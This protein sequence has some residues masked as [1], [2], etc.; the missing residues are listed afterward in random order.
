[1][2]NK[3]A[4]RAPN[5]SAKYVTS[6]RYCIRAMNAGRRCNFT[7]DNKK[8]LSNMI[9]RGKFIYEQTGATRY[10]FPL[11]DGVENALAVM[12]ITL[13]LTIPGALRNVPM[14]QW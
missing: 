8:V 14:D 6:K 5:Y 3:H 4:V 9:P 11:S 13:H 7:E 1:M 10:E 2:I 12:G